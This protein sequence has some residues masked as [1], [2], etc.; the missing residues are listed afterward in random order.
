MN[1]SLSEKL[2]QQ[3]YYSTNLIDREQHRLQARPNEISIS[4]SQGHLLRELSENDGLTQKE[5]S[6]QLQIR[7]ASLGEL[8]KKLEQNG[9]V[10]RCVNENDK[11]I[12]NVYM[13]EEGR[14]IVSEVEQARKMMVDSIFSSLSEEE[15]SQLSGL[16]GKL[17]DSMEQN[18]VDNA[19]DIRQD[20][21][22]M[23]G[24]E[25]FSGPINHDHHY[26]HR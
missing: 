20:H 2:L 10:Q 24:N 6:A 3:I 11:R 19:D 7:P 18:S 5:L 13:T 4:R 26:P 8:V 21:H 15:Q 22:K 16:I 12:S 25:D 1:Y 23:V 17:I 14:K 9:Y